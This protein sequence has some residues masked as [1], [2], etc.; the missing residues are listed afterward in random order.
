MPG[1]LDSWPIS[2]V[3][4]TSVRASSS[5]SSTGEDGRFSGEPNRES[6]VYSAANV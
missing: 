4:S 2:S 1:D 5:S 3:V 6:L